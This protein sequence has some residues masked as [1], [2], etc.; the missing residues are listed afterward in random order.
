MQQIQFI[1]INQ[2][3][4]HPDN[5]RLIKSGKF[6]DLCES[7]KRNQDYFETRPILCT[8]LPTST[9]FAGIEHPLPRFRIFAGTM[10]FRAA[11]EIGMTHVPC[12]VMDI[13]ESR[14]R[15][16]MVRDN[17]SSGEWDVQ[18]L[19]LFGEPLLIDAGFTKVELH[20]KFAIFREAEDDGFDADAEREKITEPKTKPGE[21]I[22]LGRHWVKCG[23]STNRDDVADLM[24]NER[25]DVLFTDPPYNVN[26]SY[27]KYDTFARALSY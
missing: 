4:E 12:V 1:N 17:Q 7:I 20:D 26:Y 11:K 23:D 14:Q 13:P 27:D 15:E 21:L 2:L 10:R 18:K 6:K 5:P 8:M 9:A 25:A 24:K 3:S 19:A 16:I 22:Q